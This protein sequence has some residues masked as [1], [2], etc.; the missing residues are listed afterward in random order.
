MLKSATSRQAN[1]TSSPENQEWIYEAQ[2]R[3]PVLRCR[4]V[5]ADNRITKDRWQFS[6]SKLSFS[7]H[8]LKASLCVHAFIRDDDKDRVVKQLNG[9]GGS[10]RSGFFFSKTFGAKKL[11]K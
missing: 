1:K 3:H 2:L 7:R 6:V 4:A 11:K 5:A 9:S 8:F 10:E